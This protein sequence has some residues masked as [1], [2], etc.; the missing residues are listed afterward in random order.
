MRRLSVL[1]ACG[2]LVSPGCDVSV[3]IGDGATAAPTCPVASTHPPDRLNGPLILTAQ[4]VPS[5]TLLPCLRPLP[6]GWTVSDMQAQKGKTRVVLDFGRDDDGA[7]KLT[8]VRDCNVQSAVR[9][10]SEQRGARRYERAYAARSGLRVT[11]YY[12]FR[13]GCIVH[14]FDLHG[15]TSPE[16]VATISRAL[17]FVDRAVLRRHVHDYSDGRFELDPTFE[18]GSG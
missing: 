18:R 3:N 7:L 6:A 16:P 11:R 14:D 8:L 9:R 5:A 2:I 1:L 15:A 4:S 12:V 13:G 17:G 10:N